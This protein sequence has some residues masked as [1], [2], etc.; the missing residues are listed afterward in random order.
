MTVSWLAAAA[1]LEAAIMIT[2]RR[3]GI[4]PGVLRSRTADTTEMIR[5]DNRRIQPEWMLF[6]RELAP[7]ARPPESTRRSKSFRHAMTCAR[8]TPRNPSGFMIPTNCMNSRMSIWYARPCPRVVDVGKPL[9]FGG[10]RPEVLE[11]PRREHA[12]TPRAA[13][14][15]PAVVPARGCRARSPA[16]LK[17]RSSPHGT[18]DNIFYQE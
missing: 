17:A 8:V 11:L 2:D 1:Y 12:R 16:P 18:F 6:P 5:Q 4:L 13:P 9:G 10:H 15:L 7:D 14:Q 3:E